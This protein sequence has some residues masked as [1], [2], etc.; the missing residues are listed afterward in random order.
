MR[1]ALKRQLEI[2]KQKALFLQIWKSPFLQRPFHLKI[3]K[4]SWSN[5][6]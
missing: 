4:E 3:L 6:C 2:C 1:T 5:L